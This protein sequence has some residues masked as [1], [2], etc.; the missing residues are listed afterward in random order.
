M[1]KKRG[2]GEGTI[3][4]RKDGRWCAQVSVGVDPT[5]GRIKRRTVYG[6]TRQEVAE[7]LVRLIADAQDGLLVDPSRETL[8]AYLK[9][10]M[11]TV[12]KQRV[13]P[14]TYEDYVKIIRRHIAPT[15]GNI[16]IDKL[17]PAHIQ[18]LYAQKLDEGLSPNT[19]RI[20]HAILRRA[21]AQAVKWGQIPR[22]PADAVERPRIAR[23]ET[24]ALTP[25]QVRAFLAAAREDRLYALYVLAIT[26]GMR[27]GELLGLRWEDVDLEEGRLYVRRQMIWRRNTEPHLSEPKTAKGRRPVEL[28]PMAADALRQHR[29][30]QVEE[31]L[32]AGPAWQDRWGLVFTTS[33][34]T[35]INPSNLRS[36]SFRKV[37]QRAGLPP[38]RFH[39][40]RHTHA[41]MLLAAGVHPKLVQERL[42]HSTVAIT[43]D[44]YSHATPAMHRQVADTVEQLL[45]PA[46]ENRSGLQ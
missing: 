15:L 45:R 38:I 4:R 13:R 16:R 1:A 33:I 37:L 2:H 3:Y 28:P 29:K 46:E 14:Q 39:D 35:P 10:W 41:T 12:Q 23:R 25:E 11:E 36:R 43:L 44:V 42:G 17:Q 22:N 9:R 27:Q 8:A 20:I 19:V 5:T 26:T 7:T 18:T 24:P 6:R 30:Q 32:L 21:L 40:L 31:R 34:G